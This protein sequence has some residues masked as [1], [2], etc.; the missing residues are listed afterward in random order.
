ML[1]DGR[2]WPKLYFHKGGSKEF[3]Q[4]LKTY[5]IFKKY[6]HKFYDWVGFNWKSS[7]SPLKRNPH[8]PRLWSV[9]IQN[10]EKFEQSL[11]QLSLFNE[12]REHV[13]KKFLN[14][15]I[16][17]TLLGFSRVTNMV[18]DALNRDVVSSTSAGGYT[19]QQSSNKFSPNSFEE[20]MK[21]YGKNKE[22][23]AATSN[24]NISAGGDDIIADLMDSLTL[25]NIHSTVND[26]YEMVTKVDLGPM[27]DV[28]IIKT[29]D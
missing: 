2:V 27:P 23:T 24:P 17:S 16:Q 25:D 7:S 19:Q 1:N 21:S 18:R 11:Y 10:G 15:P 8:D 28:C 6:F 26:G 4:E 3:L 12:Q 13:M 5:F 29:K 9:Q 14:E 20:A 22:S